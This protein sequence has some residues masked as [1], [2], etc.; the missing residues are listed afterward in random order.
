[1]VIGKLAE[2]VM[3]KLGIF[4]RNNGVAA[5]DLENVADAYKAV[6]YVLSDD[7]LVS[8]AYS[9][10]DEADIPDRFS[11]SLINLIAAEIADF[12]SVSPPAEGWLATKE[13][14]TRQIRKQLA[15]GQPTETV[16]AEYY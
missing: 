4:D 12:Y 5:E 14:A 8:W 7:G 2:K 10:S 16:T 6:Y 1:M 13:M 11:L 9:A 3:Q 15:S